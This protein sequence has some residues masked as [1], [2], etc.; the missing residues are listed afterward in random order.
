M[1]TELKTIFCQGPHALKS[2]RAYTFDTEDNTVLYYICPGNFSQERAAEIV[3][4]LV[5]DT[6][7][8]V[9]AKVISLTGESEAVKCKIFICKSGCK[10]HVIS[11]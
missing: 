8:A 9:V 6:V 2:A 7:K 1:T 5:E 4:P 3:T 10:E 11:K